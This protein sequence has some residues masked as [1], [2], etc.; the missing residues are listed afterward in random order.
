MQERC[1]VGRVIAYLQWPC[2]CAFWL[3]RNC[4]ICA[5]VQLTSALQAHSY[6]RLKLAI[7]NDLLL[8]S[9]THSLNIRRP[10]SDGQ[11]RFAWMAKTVIAGT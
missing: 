2:G 5:R 3:R 1:C 11:N 7:W 10:Y 9:N 8:L 4:H 6:R